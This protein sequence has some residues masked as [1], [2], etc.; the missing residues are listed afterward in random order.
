MTTRG[1]RSGA[2][3]GVALGIATLLTAINPAAT[4][5]QAPG[6]GGGPSIEMYRGHPVFAGEVLV[7]LRPNADRARL[8][9]AV[10]ADSDS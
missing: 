9:A 10:D 8:R 5:A 1:P 3:V 4:P 2:A 6:P 7:A